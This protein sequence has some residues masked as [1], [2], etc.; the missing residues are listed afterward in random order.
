MAC[1]QA[2][3]QPLRASN[4]GLAAAHESAKEAP[5]PRA[6]APALVLCQ[7]LMHTTL[8]GPEGLAH[9][10]AL[11]QCGHARAHI[12]APLLCLGLCHAL[13]LGLGLK[14]ALGS[15]V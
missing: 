3:E 5:C 6:H 1:A 13:R 2:P 4:G 10:K 9:A 8:Q 14:L 12:C 15:P 11:K 7:R